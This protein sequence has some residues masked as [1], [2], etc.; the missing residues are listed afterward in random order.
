MTSAID[1]SKPSGPMAYTADVRA[2]F[3]AAHDEITALQAGGEGGDYLPLTGGTITADSSFAAEGGALTIVAPSQDAILEFKGG[4]SSYYQIG[5]RQDWD[6]F[7]IGR[8]GVAFQAAL[9]A[10]NL[11]NVNISYLSANSLI[12]R[13]SF[14]AADTCNPI[15][16]GDA[17]FNRRCIVQPPVYDG[18]AA[19][20]AYVDGLVGGADPLTLTQ[21]LTLDGSALGVRYSALGSDGAS[22]Q[23][24]MVWD[25]SNFNAWV[26]GTNVGALANHNFVNYQLQ[27]YLPLSG[28]ATM[29]GP[30]ILA[31]DPTTAMHASTKQYVDAAV[32]PLLARIADLESRL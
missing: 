31:A 2:N 32:A 16:Q 12:V 14:T 11:G 23:T 20:K 15:F 21:G 9:T 10:D 30:I 18:D 1:P 25:G 29:T 13:T 19:T 7:A 24:A 17:L 8:P 27:S 5:Y 26:D 4:S 3:Q 6:C 22:H 28:A